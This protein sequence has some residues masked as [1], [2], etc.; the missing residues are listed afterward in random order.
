MNEV[1]KYDNSINQTALAGLKAGGMDLFMMLCAMARDKGTDLLVFDYAIV[2]KYMELSHQDNKYVSVQ[3]GAACDII[4]KLR[5]RVYD[6]ETGAC[7]LRTLFPTCDNYPDKEEVVIRVNPDA[8]DLLNEITKN[9]TRFELSEFVRLESRYAKS[10]Y[11]LL[12]QYRKTGTYKVAVDKFRELMDCP[13]S[14][15]NKEFMRRCINPAIKEL[16]QGYFDN[17]TVTPIRSAKRG[18]PITAY[19]FTFRKSDQTPG[20]MSIDDIPEPQPEKPEKRTARRK[21]QGTKFNN[22]HE[23]ENDYAGIEST[24]LQATIADQEDK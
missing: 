24:L 21:S 23:R 1:V 11:R 14:Y 4:N 2:R 3:L 5:F 8:V 17:L 18:A 13:K 10:L 22:F 15:Q 20:Q 9:F 16:S 19:K 7:R 12:K 6:E